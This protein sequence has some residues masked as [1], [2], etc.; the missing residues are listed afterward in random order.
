MKDG[1]EMKRQI[2]YGV[3]ET[4]SSSVHTIVI[5]KLNYNYK[6][7]KEIEFSY[8]TFGWEFESGNKVSD[9][10]FTAIIDT[11]C[12]K[13]EALEKVKKLKLILDKYNIKYYINMPTVDDC[14][15]YGEKY[16]RVRDSEEL[17]IDHGYYLKEFV[18]S[19]LNDEEKLLRFLCGGMVFT[20][21]D[22]CSWEESGFIFRNKPYFES[23]DGVVDNVVKNPYYMENWK[24]Y[25]WSIKYN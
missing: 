18:D 23:S 11:S 25:D 21:N 1:S 14:E 2:R 16:I 24:D 4:N 9:Y 6:L 8:R 22:N 12:E 19:L 13:S 7:P 3:F 15:F 17:G 10:L 5:P 20:G